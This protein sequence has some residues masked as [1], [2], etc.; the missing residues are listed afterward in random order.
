M[1]NENLG[2]R[3]LMRRRRSIQQQ[4]E[5]WGEQMGEEGDWKLG[6]ADKCWGKIWEMKIAAEGNGG[7]LGGIERKMEEKYG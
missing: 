5:F 6:W 1:K 2:V 3:G 4:G 7:T